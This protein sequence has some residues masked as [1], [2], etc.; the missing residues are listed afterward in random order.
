MTPTILIVNPNSNMKMQQSLGLNIPSSVMEKLINIAL[1]NERRNSDF[2][3]SRSTDRNSLL[4]QR[5]IRCS[6]E[7]EDLNN[8]IREHNDD[9]PQV[10][11]ESAHFSDGFETKEVV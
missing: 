8:S 1:K 9:Y 6:A 11:I 10:I 2:S 3:S 5:I 7:N 4:S